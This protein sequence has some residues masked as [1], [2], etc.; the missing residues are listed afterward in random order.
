MVQNRH[1]QFLPDNPHSPIIPGV[2]ELNIVAFKSYA[3]VIGSE[4]VMLIILEYSTCILH[5]EEQVIS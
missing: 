3:K 5:K 1:S 4:L 2:Q